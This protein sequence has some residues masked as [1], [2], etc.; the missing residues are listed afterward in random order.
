MKSLR[1]I[2]LLVGLAFAAPTEVTPRNI[3]STQRV[4]LPG[5]TIG[6]DIDPSIIG[7]PILQI[8]G[9]DGASLERRGMS[10]G[11][12]E[13]ISAL[14]PSTKTTPSGSNKADFSQGGPRPP[15]VVFAEGLTPRG[16]DLGLRQ[17]LSFAGGPRHDTV[18]GGKEGQVKKISNGKEQIGGG[19]KVGDKKNSRFGTKIRENKFLRFISEASPEAFRP[20]ADAIKGGSISVQDCELAFKRS[21]SK[22][23]EKRY[24]EFGSFNKAADSLK[25]IIVDISK[26]ARFGTP[27]GFWEDVIKELPAIA[28]EV[29]KGK[30][31]TEKLEIANRDIHPVVKAWSYT[32]IGALNEFLMQEAANK[33]PIVQGTAVAI[34]KL[35]SY[36]PFGWFINRVF[37]VEPL[38]RQSNV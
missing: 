29:S 34:N 27:I 3:S 14:D 15:L 12:R 30:T 20:L 32:P 35:W 11:A 13:A 38:I 22:T 6:T 23:I 28:K 16:A 36:T 31:P 2:S 7:K 19:P 5:E 37:P 24:A 26:S 4:V 17:H 8:V 21:L 1:L 33:T 10:D 9:D 25:N 18:S